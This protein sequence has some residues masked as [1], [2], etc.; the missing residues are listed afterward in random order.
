[1]LKFCS[2]LSSEKDADALGILLNEQELMSWTI[3]RDISL[4]EYFLCG[5]VDNEEAGKSDFSRIERAFQGI[6]AAEI[7]PISEKDWSVEYKKFIKPWQCD[8]LYWIP[9]WM[10]DEVEVPDNMACVYI[11]PGM[12][13]GSGTHETTQLCGRSLS[14]FRMLY[15]K[16]NDLVIKNC[17]DVGCGSGILGISAMKL[18]LSHVTFIDIDEDAVRISQEN[19]RLNGIFSDQMDFVVGDLKVGLL[20]RQT[21]LLLANIFSDVLIENADLLI[22]SVR[23]G[24]LLCLSGFLKVQKAE[25]SSVF[26]KFAKLRWGHTVLE[27]SMDEGDWTV[28]I[29]FHD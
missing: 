2:K 23:P 10:K 19:A 4:E 27:N 15:E 5:Y 13:F 8:N 29:Y 21:D 12:A 24:G 7:T 11:D 3:E 28:L 16:T 6:G 1:M 22:N 18:G 25:I 9:V 14:M 17:I 20:G 26:G